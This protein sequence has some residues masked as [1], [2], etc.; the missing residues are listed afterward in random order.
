LLGISAPHAERWCSWSL[1][2]GGYAHWHN[3]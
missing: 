1:L 3:I 2:K